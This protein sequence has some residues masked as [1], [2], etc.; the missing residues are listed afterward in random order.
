MPADPERTS[1]IIG[2]GQINDRP[3]RPEDG[4]DSLGLMVAAARAAAADAGLADLAGMDSL[5]VVAQ[6]SC[7]YDGPLDGPIATALGAAPTHSEY[8]PLPHGDTPVRMLNDAANRIGAGEARLALVTGG[9]ALRTA[10][11][12]AKRDS[13]LPRGPR[14]KD[15][16]TYAQ[17]FGLVTPTDVYPLYENALRAARGQSLAAGQA[18]SAAIWARMSQVAATSP[19]AWLRDPVSAAGILTPDERNRPIAFPYTKL[20]VANSAVNQGAAFL[21]ASVAEARRRGIADARMVHIGYGAGAREPSSILAR[22]RYDRSASMEMVLRQ[23]MARNGIGAGDLDHVELY[24]CFPCV[25]KLARDNIGWDHGR[26]VTMFGGLTFGGGPIANYMSHAIAAMV[27]GLRG[28]AQRGLLYANGGFVTDSHAILLGGAPL[29]GVCFP[30]DWNVQ[31]LADAARGAVPSLA[32]DYLGPACIETYTIFYDR[33]GAASGGVVIART[34]DA[35]RTLAHV[36]PGDA[37]LVSALT[38]GSFEPVGRAGRIA[39]RNGTRYWQFD[40]D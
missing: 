10:A 25:P 19:G 7:R 4:L 34:P 32:Q 35:E 8:S 33:T 30:D 22:D 11:A 26:P 9:E 27:D 38:D 37:A 28:S 20:M 1:V 15:A 2:V 17:S 36:D 14:I 16:P 24:S 3:G 29:T 18:E 23:V 6:I 13:S 21:V 5:G 12:L 40:G 31:S 39:S